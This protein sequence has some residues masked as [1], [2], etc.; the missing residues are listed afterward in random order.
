VSG[1]GGTDDGLSMIEVLVS[2]VLMS[3][4]MAMFFGGITQMFRSDYRAESGGAAQTQINLAFQRLDRQIRYAA[5]IS[6]DGTMFGDPVIEYLTTSGASATCTEL[7]LNAGSGQ[8]QIRT[9][10][11]GASPLVPGRWLPLAS[12]VVPAADP[13]TFLPADSTLNFQRLELKLS[14]T[15]GTGKDQATRASDLTFTALNTS[16][17]TGSDTVCTEG[18]AIP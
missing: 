14:V 17:G 6:N 7:R 13:F 10:T 12:Q 8:L 18:R 3:I 2:M 5:G 15:D 4:F 11:Q 16:L 1:T 9:W